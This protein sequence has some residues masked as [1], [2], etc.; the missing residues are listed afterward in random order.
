MNNPSARKNKVHWLAILGSAG[1]HVVLGLLAFFG[2]P[3]FNQKAPAPVPVITGSLI[4]SPTAARQAREAEAQRHK[5]ER[6][7]VRRAEEAHRKAAEEEARRQEE[8]RQREIAEARAKEEAAQKAREEAAR[9][10]AERKAEEA[11]K[12]ELARKAEEAKRVAE[13]KAKEEAERKAREAAEKKAREE[14]AR[15]KAE[16]ER[17][18]KEEAKRKKAEAE[19][20][21]REAAL[22]E[23]LSAEQ[24]QMDRTTWGDRLADHLQK[25]WIRPAGADSQFSCVVRIR[26]SR[27]GDVLA[28]SILR[29]CGND[30]LDNSVLEAVD[31]ASPLP[32]PRNPRVFEPEIDLTFRPL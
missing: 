1:L 28:R 30:F 3:Q 6:E 19:K 24:D 14:A 4:E 15:K 10:E 13:R 27:Y 21:E 5:E 22:A 7:R 32:L 25:F 9:Q 23:A 16:A 31:N 26:Q 20:R 2:L 17:K 11:R 8:Q 12:A 29:S 18:A